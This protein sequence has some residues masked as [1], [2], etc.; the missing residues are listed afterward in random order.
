MNLKRGKDNPAMEKLQRGKRKAFIF[1]AKIGA[2]KL[3]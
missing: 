2:V 1:Y 3:G